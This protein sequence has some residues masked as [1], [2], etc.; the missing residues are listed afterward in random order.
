MSQKQIGRL[1]LK[2]G[3]WI[4]GVIFELSKI[5]VKKW[6]ETSMSYSSLAATGERTRRGS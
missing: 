3:N 1:N 5:G 4:C 6:V 2:H